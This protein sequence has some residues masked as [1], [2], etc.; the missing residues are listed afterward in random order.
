MGGF[1]EL[2]ASGRLVELLLAFVVLEAVLIIG[3]R[4]WRGDGIAPLPLLLN[5]AAGASLMLALN[6]AVTGSG[7]G[8]I[9]GWLVAAL[10]FHVGDFAVRWDRTAQDIQRRQ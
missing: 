8:A 3:Y 10:V 5:L 4:S 1:G 6:A 7:S 9:A 2:L